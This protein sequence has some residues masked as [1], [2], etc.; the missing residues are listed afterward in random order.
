MSQGDGAVLGVR[1]LKTVFRTR[2]GAIHAVNSVSFDLKPGELLGVVG[3]SG[4]GKSVTMMSLIGLVPSPP[5]EVDGTHILFGGKDLLRVG[6]EELR[7]VRGK[8]IGFIFQDPM[9][10][11]NPVFTVGF[12]LMEPLRKRLGMGKKAARVRAV[13]LLEL[14]GIPDAKRRLGD[15]P[16]QFSGGMRQRVMIAIALS[17]DPKVL[18]ADEPTTALDVTI[19]AQILE[20]VKDLRKKLGMAIIWI[21]HDLG[22]IAGI[23]DRVM[24]MYGG[25]VVEQATAHELFANPQHPYTRSLLATVPSVRGVRPPKLTVIEGQP[26]ILFEAPSTC[27]FYDRCDRHIDG[28]LAA[29]PPLRSIATGHE[30]ACIRVGEGS[31]MANG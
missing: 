27:S 5:A 17:C 1:D 31:E 23:A 2:Q 15:Y 7:V 21:T 11:L 14:V 8:E 24:V 26:P 25:Q 28:C 12:Q 22:V 3:E 9:T 4:S 30:A 6:E 18:I 29:N 19:Q 10:S 20:L 16:H 13:E